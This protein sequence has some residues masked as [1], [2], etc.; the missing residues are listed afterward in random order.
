[1]IRALGLRFNDSSDTALHRGVYVPLRRLALCL[2]CENCFELTYGSCPAC[3]SDTWSSLAR[4]LETASL[5]EPRDGVRQVVVVAHEQAAMHQALRRA[6]SG[7]GS[8]EVVLDRRRPGGAADG[9]GSRVGDR[10]GESDVA[11]R[12]DGW[13]V[14]RRAPR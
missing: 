4:F 10:R 11:A 8:V 3:G 2:D 12:G 6:F 13:C 1:M 9:L 7:N 5:G 14:V